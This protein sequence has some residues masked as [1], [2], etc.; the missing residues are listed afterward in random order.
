M[1]VQSQ[2]ATALPVGDNEVF[3]NFWI[4]HL[5]DGVVCCSILLTQH[6]IFSHKMTF[7]VLTACNWGFRS[8]T[9]DDTVCD[10]TRLWNCEIGKG[11]FL[12]M[13]RNFV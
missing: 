3:S 13:L 12:C 5:S 6:A 10:F 2:K 4:N 7:W 9:A 8:M 11:L 1:A